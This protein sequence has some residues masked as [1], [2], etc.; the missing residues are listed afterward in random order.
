MNGCL[1]VDLYVL[2]FNIEYVHH[3][4]IILEHINYSHLFFIMNLPGVIISDISLLKFSP[5]LWGI[6]RMEIWSNCGGAETK[7]R[8]IRIW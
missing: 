1:V 8:V 7:P 2:I 3:A 4:C 5:H 6:K